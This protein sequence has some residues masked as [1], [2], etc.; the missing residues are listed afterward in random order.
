ESSTLEFTGSNG[1]S[2]GT[3][4]TKEPLK[5]SAT[6]VD[7]EVP[8][9]NPEILPQFPG[10]FNALIKFLRKNLNTPQEL[11]Q[12]EGITVKVRFIVNYNGQLMG[13]D[14]I[15]SGGEPFDNEVIRVLK[16]MPEWIPGKTNGEN[17]SVY[18]IVPVKF[19]VLN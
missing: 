15:K 5:S 19:T 9:N 2:K 14:V 16:K 13:F 8:V 7:R 17:V 11:Q 3:E 18:F 6:V 12:G 10:G 1:D 4:E